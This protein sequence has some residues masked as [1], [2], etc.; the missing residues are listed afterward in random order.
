[1]CLCIE[2]VHTVNKAMLIMY[3]QAKVIPILTYA[4]PAWYTYITEESKTKLERHQ[5]M[6]LR[7]VYP[8]VE[9]YTTRLQLASIDRL[10]SVML[11]LCLRFAHKIRDDSCHPLH[12]LVPPKQSSVGRHSKRI[13]D[14]YALKPKTDGLSKSLFS[15]LH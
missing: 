6:C 15:V 10:N 3:Y 11:N 9:S 14:R 4:C 13:A 5:S 7:I 8:N 12:P 2:V 1:M